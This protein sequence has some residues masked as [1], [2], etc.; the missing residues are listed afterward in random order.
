ML[1]GTGLP[2]SLL[3][4]DWQSLPKIMFND[5][6]FAKCIDF[7]KVFIV[8]VKNISNKYFGFDNMFSFR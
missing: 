2:S 1:G 8:S 4:R 5:G 3:V 7:T 6:K